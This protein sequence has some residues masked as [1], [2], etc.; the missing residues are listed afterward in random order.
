MKAGSIANIDATP[1]E[2]AG[3]EFGYWAKVFEAHYQQE[4]EIWI[5][6]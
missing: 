3:L 6:Q 2:K 4:V 5:K 1:A